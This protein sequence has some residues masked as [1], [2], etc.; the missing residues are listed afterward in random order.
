M[1]YNPTTDAG[2][3]RLLITDTDVADPIFTDTEISQ[4]LS[5]SDNDIYGAAALAFGTI[6][7]SRALLA[8]RMQREGYE[9]EEHALSE[10]RKCVDD[11]STLSITANGVQTLDWDLSDEHLESYRPSWRDE[12]TE[13]VE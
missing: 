1:S 7:R 3:V 10:L 6:I 13:V 5:M 2:K 11:L 4:F 9:T 12:T 8:K